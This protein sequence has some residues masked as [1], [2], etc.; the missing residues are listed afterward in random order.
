M[1]DDLFDQLLLSLNCPAA[2]EEDRR[3]QNSWEATGTVELEYLVRVLGDPAETVIPQVLPIRLLTK[4]DL[5]KME[6]PFPP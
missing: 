1:S 2:T 5:L 6:C 3:A 4:A